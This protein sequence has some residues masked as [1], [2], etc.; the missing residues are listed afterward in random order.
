MVL[1]PTV[2][3]GQDAIYEINVPASKK[4]I[5]REMKE[6]AA[7]VYSYDGTDG[8]FSYV[9]MNAPFCY[10]AE[11]PLLEV[12][13]FEIYND[14]VYFCGKGGGVAVAGFFD[15]NATFFL[16]A[17]AQYVF[18]PSSI[19][20]YI[21]PGTVSYENILD[22]KKIE[23]MDNPRGKPHMLMIGDATCTHSGNMV[24]RCIVD[25]YH[26]GTNW[27]IAMTQEHESI[28]YFDDIAVTDNFVIAAGHK[29]PQDGEY[30]TIFSR[31]TSPFVNIFN[32]LFPSGAQPYPVH[33]A[34]GMMCYTTAWDEDYLVEHI[35]GDIFATIGHGG[36]YGL[37]NNIGGTVLNLYTV[38]S[39]Y[40]CTVYNRLF[41]MT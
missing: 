31:P 15:I 11:I 25:V 33:S 27:E 2:A 23:V 22:L 17:S 16:G 14:T 5:V 41:R 18:M 19:P 7:I 40:A 12:N 1:F 4:T 8:R 37:P 20:C 32:V 6:N 39:P 38:T 30:L 21:D 36:Y 3:N 34:G 28:L 24:N 26:N 9:D 13:D 29:H 10:S 35:T